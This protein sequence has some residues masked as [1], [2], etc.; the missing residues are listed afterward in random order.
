[1]KVY[2]AG[3]IERFSFTEAN[4]WKQVVTQQLL[5]KSN[6]EITTISPLRGYPT[7][8]GNTTIKEHRDSFNSYCT[9]PKYVLSRD[10]NDIKSSDAVLFRLSDT[11]SIGTVME[12]GLAHA[13]KKFIVAV[14]P[15]LSPF[16]THPLSI[17]IVDVWFTTF[18]E[19]VEC[20]VSY[21]N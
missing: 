7:Y 8:T 18:V 9:N 17:G 21:K 15:S 2:L 5:E 14:S 4:D 16:R 11:Q 1:M 13:E 12:L 20:L 6:G 10:Y 19:A 3:P